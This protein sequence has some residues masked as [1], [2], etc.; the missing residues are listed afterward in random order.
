MSVT[1]YQTEQNLRAFLDTEDLVPAEMM[2]EFSAE[3]VAAN[4]AAVSKRDGVIRFIRHCESQI[5]MARAEEKRIADW[6]KSLEGGLERFEGYVARVIETNVPEPNKGP[7]KLVGRVGEIRLVKKPGA[8]VITDEAAIP[9]AFKRITVSIPLEQWERMRTAVVR[10]LAY[11]AERDG[12]VSGAGLVGIFEVPGKFDVPLAPIKKAIEAGEDV[13]GAD[14]TVNQ[15]RL[16][17]K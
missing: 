3:L 5:E 11:L 12:A 9:D 14:L 16:E 8:V 10:A 1:L 6:R 2:A 13:P 4:D 15:F 17:V 7:R